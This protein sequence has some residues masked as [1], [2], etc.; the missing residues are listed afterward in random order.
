M[1]PNLMRPKSMSI[2]VSG[3][4][5]SATALSGVDIFKALLQSSMLNLLWHVQRR[6]DRIL[7]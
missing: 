4:E 6:D 2:D 7:K 3:V 1:N 5:V